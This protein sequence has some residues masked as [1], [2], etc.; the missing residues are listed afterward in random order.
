MNFAMKEEQKEIA[1]RC[2]HFA[3]KVIAPQVK[4]LEEDLEL[5][6]K[7]FQQMAIEGLFTL[8]LPNKDKKTETIGYLAGLTAIAK[9]D[10]GIA[11]A[12]A[13]TNMVAEAIEKFGTEKQRSYY[14][15]KIADGTCAPLSF[16]MTE[17]L[18]G[19]DV[20]A[21]QTIFVVD[22]KDSDFIVLNGSKQFITNGDMAGALVVF[23]K[24][25]LDCEEEG[26]SAFLV[27]RGAKGFSVIKKENKLGLLTANLVALKFENCRISKNAILG[28]AGEGLKIA[29]SSLDSGRLGIAAQSIG[30][31][32]AAFEAALLFSKERFQF[33][34]VIGA[35]QAVAFKLADMRVKLDAAR[36][37]AF[38]A[39]WLKDEKAPFT[40]QA[41]EAKLY[42][43]EVCNEIAAEA[44][45][46]HGGY[47]YIKD[48]LVEKYFRDARVTTIY[49]G[50]SEIQRIVIARHLTSFS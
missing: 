24:G 10:A 43:S 37:M 7:V 5:R 17:K 34:H 44:L 49:E 18:A 21:I 22:P 41:A 38:Y 35:N 28:P 45:Q 42:C 14:L 19:S 8:A 3:E 2:K 32:E 23:A 31:A 33:G 4:Q 46:I 29:F 26:I 16:A 47:G 40:Q 11:V 20:K 1:S 36:L 6:Q 15:P 13:V 12:M 25:R 48:Y 27:D 9:V 39:A 30:I 50:T